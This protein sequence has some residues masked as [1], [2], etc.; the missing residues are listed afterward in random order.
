MDPA[1]RQRATRPHAALSRMSAA[2]KERVR[3]PRALAVG[4][5]ADDGVSADG[6]PTVGDPAHLPSYPR[7]PRGFDFI[8]KVNM[9]TMYCTLRGWSA[10]PT[11]TRNVV[12]AG[13]GYIELSI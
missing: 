3:W 8:G 5:S 13:I 1:A 10:Q 11:T 6:V 9:N 12:C 2:F 4:S 7:P